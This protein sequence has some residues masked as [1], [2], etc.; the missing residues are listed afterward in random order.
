MMAFAGIKALFEQEAQPSPFKVAEKLAQYLET[1]G[2]YQDDLAVI[3]LLD[4]NGF[5]SPF[6]RAAHVTLPLMG[7]TSAEKMMA[8]RIG[9]MQIYLQLG[10]PAQPDDVAALKMR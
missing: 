4:T 6:K 7:E 2:N 8:A 3:A 10:A 9:N 1:R 5:K